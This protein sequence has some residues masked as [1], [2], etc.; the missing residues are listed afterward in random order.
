MTTDEAL[1]AWAFKL[2]D[3]MSRP[4]VESIA[5]LRAFAEAVAAAERERAAKAVLLH[6]FGTTSIRPVPPAVV[7]NCLLAAGDA[8][9]ALTGLPPIP[10]PK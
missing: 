8:V 7:S 10:E 5:V 2:A 1:R 3:S 9:R 4:A 6:P